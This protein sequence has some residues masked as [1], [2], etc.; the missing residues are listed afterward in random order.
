[1]GDKRRKLRINDPVRCAR[2]IAALT[3]CAAFDGIKAAINY[4]CQPHWFLIISVVALIVFLVFYRTLTKPVVAGIIGAV[5]T[6]A[7]LASCLDSNFILIVKKA[8]NGNVYYHCSGGRCAHE[9]TLWCGEW[10]E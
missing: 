8:D 7:F 5:A 6:L 10:D 1:M 2:R 4:L 3:I 9:E